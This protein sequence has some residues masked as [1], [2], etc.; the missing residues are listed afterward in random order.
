M[1]HRIL[2]VMLWLSAVAVAGP[3]THD[4]DDKTALE[5]IQLQSRNRTP[6]VRIAMIQAGTTKQGAFEFA[7][8]R[9]VVTVEAVVEGGAKVRRMACREFHW[10]DE[11][12]WFTWE[13]RKERGGEAIWIWSE[14]KGEVVIR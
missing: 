10:S 2:V 3:P 4:L 11:Y 1:I 8:V 9:R 14:L 6:D 5:I 7:H 12:G 13:A